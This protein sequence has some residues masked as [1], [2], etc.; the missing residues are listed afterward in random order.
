MIKHS[1]SVHDAAVLKDSALYK[2][3][4]MIIKYI[5]IIL[6]ELLLNSIIGYVIDE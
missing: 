1:A 5:C 3:V 6:K 4:N 2:N